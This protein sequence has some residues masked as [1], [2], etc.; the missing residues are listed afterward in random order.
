MFHVE[1]YLL[2]IVDKYIYL[3]HNIYNK[4]NIH[5]VQ[6]R[7][8]IID[9]RDIKQYDKK[10]RTLLNSCFLLYIQRNLRILLGR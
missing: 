6:K 9:E 4:L 3:F 8:I 1:Q 2:V 7:E 10:E 5:F